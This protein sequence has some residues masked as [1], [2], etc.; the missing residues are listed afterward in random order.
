MKTLSLL[1]AVVLTLLPYHVVADSLAYDTHYDVRSGSLTQVACSDGA[2]GLITKGFTT[3]G[4]LPSFP[5]IG[6]VGA[7]TGWNST[8]CGSCWEVTYTNST[9][10]KKSL[11][12]T[13]IDVSSPGNFNVAQAAMNTLTNNNA[14]QFGRVTVTSRQVPASGCG[15]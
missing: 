1:S 3:Y 8:A 13:A 10:V 4:S 9:G 15:L 2:N 11:N 12:I 6:A 5:N 14:V 7:V